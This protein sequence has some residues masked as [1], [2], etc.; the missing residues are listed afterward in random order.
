MEYE[1]CEACNLKSG[2]IILRRITDYSYVEETIKTIEKHGGE[3]FIA[4]ENSIDGVS[5]IAQPNHIFQ[6]RWR[7]L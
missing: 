5:I 3:Y 7:N 1:Y 2:D 6:Y 4:L